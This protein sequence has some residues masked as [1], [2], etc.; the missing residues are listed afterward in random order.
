MVYKNFE[1]SYKTYRTAWS[2]DADAF[3]LEL[4]PV[5][6]ATT[7]DAAH[8]TKVAV[9]AAKAAEGAAT[10]TYIAA[11]EAEQRR[12]LPHQRQQQRGLRPRYTTTPAA[13]TFVEESN[14]ICGISGSGLQR[15]RGHSSPR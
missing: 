10:T 14:K 6:V 15:A 4:D 9:A 7:V 12:L 2:G 1:K 11:G 3:E 8:A 13:G 5:A